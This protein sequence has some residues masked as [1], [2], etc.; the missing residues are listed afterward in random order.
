MSRAAGLMFGRHPRAR[1]RTPVVLASIVVL[2]GVVV[3][4][5]S[6]PA[7]ASGVAYAPG[8]V[9]ASVGNSQVKHF[10]NTGTL[11]DTLTE[12]TTSQ[13]T[14]GMAFDKADNLYVTD[15]LSKTVS[16][17]DSTG[18]YVSVFA[19]GFAGSP[20]SIVF[21]NIG[22][23]YVGQSSANTVV[24]LDPTGVPIGVFTVQTAPLIPDAGPNYLALAAD[25]CT[26]LYTSFDAT[27]R[28]FNVCT[29]SQNPPFATTGLTG[30]RTWA[31]RIRANGEVL[32]ADANDVVRFNSSGSPVQTYTIPNHPNDFNLSAL[33]LDPD[34]TSF[35]IGDA[36][37]GDVFR[38]D[39]ASGN[40]LTTFAAN[41]NTDLGGLAVF[42]E[43]IASVTTTSTTLLTTTTPSS[44]TSSSTTL[45]KTTTTLCNPGYGYGDNN[46]CHSGPPGQNKTTSSTRPRH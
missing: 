40:V 2:V 17:F 33:S 45:P 15:F 24:K 6:I 43:I 32:V 46:H 27:V 11:K 21:D 28:S 39:I 30:N 37:T 26:L 20:R 29:N 31:L 1:R 12:A 23:A 3:V 8:D 22:N 35:W 13:F 36:G 4:I 34:N 14:V 16:K 5:A 25:Q 19:T 38:V 10:D 41:P 7:N 44:T 9:F 18:N 42:H